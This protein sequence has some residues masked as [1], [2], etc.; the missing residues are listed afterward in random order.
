MVDRLAELAKGLTGETAVKVK[1]SYFLE[2]LHMDCVAA[3][4]TDISLYGLR[5]SFAS[6]C[7][8]ARIS[9]LQCMQWGGW[10]DQQTMHKIY[11]HI[12]EADETDDL[13]KMRSL[14]CE[15]EAAQEDSAH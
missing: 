10:S 1:Y 3:G 15:E 5:H 4:V 13:K 12:A 7:H 9:E 8:H 2:H 6:L 14:F 11:T